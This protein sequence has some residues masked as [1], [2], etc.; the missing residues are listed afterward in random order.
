MSTA[1]TDITQI[2]TDYATTASVASDVSDI[3]TSISTLQGEVTTNKE[4][5]T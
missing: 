1:E 2:K 5:I 4:D 3:N